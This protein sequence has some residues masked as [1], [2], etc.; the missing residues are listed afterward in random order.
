MKLP[1]IN[2]PLKSFSL[3][4]ATLLLF[5]APSL[6]L[7]GITLHIS[8]RLA[9]AQPTQE[10]Q[11]EADQL[12]QQGIEQLNNSQPEA[13]LQL[14]QQALAIYQEL[15]NRQGE[16]QVLKNIG[17]TY[18]GL[19]EYAK[20]IE[21]HEQ[22]LAIAQEL[23]DRDL[24]GKALNNLGLAYKELGDSAKAIEYYQ[25]ALV[26]AREVPSSELEQIVLGNLVVIYAAL[27]EPAKVIEYAKPVLLAAQA[28]ENTLLEGTALGY[29]GD[30]SVSLKNYQQGIDYAQQ[31]LVIA[32]ETE[33]TLLEAY[34]F[35]ILSRAYSS[36]ENYQKVIEYA[37]QGLLAAQKIENSWLEGRALGQ[38]GDTHKLRG[39]MRKAIE[40]AQQSLVIAQESGNR[41]LESW[42][43]ITLSDAY[44]FIGDHLQAIEYAQQ[45][46]TIAQEIESSWFQMLALDTLGRAYNSLGQTE[47]SIDFFQ[48]SLTIAQ[49]VSSPRQEGIV[50]LNLSNNYEQ[51]EDYQKAI[52]LLEQSLAIGRKSKNPRLEAQALSNLS[53]V[54]SSLNDYK[55]AIELAEQSW[56]IAQE[57][58]NPQALMMPLVSLYSIYESLGDYQKLIEVS[59]RGLTTAQ[60]IENPQ[61]EILFL[62]FLGMASFY[63]GDAQK[64]IELSQQSLVIAEQNESKLAEGIALL[65]LS[66][67]YGELK[68]YEKAIE[69]S[70]KSLTIAKELQNSHIERTVLNHL[71]GIYRRAGQKKQ[72]L[73][74]YQEALAIAQKSQ[75]DFTLTNALAGM[76]LVYR[77]LNMPV[78]AITY[79]KQ[80]IN[81][82][83][84]VRSN[85]SGLSTELQESFL[86]AIWDF[87]RFTRADFYRELA[88]LLL[89]QGRILEAQQVLE[90]LKVQELRD[91][92]GN[93]SAG[94]EKPKVSLTQTEEQIK[95]EHGTL[96]AFGQKV[97]EC[98]AEPSC[99]ELEQM[100]QQLDALIVQ[101]NQTVQV[102]EEKVQNR[103]E[104]DRAFL[105]TEDF[106]RKAQEIVKAQPHTVL[107]YPFVLDDKIWLLWS[108]AG[109]IV[110]TTEVT[111]VGQQ[112]LS[113]TVL[114]FREQLQDPYSEI[115]ALQTTGK[116]LYDWLIKPLEK[117]LQGN[118]IQNLVFS[119]DRATR[120][121]PLSALFDGE[122]YLI[123]NYA[124][125]TV[126]S[127]KL[128]DTE[129]RLPSNPQ[130]TSVLAMGLSDAVEGFNPL[131]NVPPELDVI[132]LVDD[133]DSRGVYSGSQFL[134]QE[135]NLKALRK[136]LRGRQILHLAT[137]GEFVPGRPKESYILLGTGEK[138]AIADISR[139]Y[140][141]L[142]D[143]HLVVL[144]ACETALGGAGEDGVEINGISYYF[145]SNGA[146]AVMASLWLVNDASTSQLMQQFYGNLAN[147]TAIVPMT[148]AQALRQAQLSMLKDNTSTTDN[149]DDRASITSVS[150]SGTPN[151]STAGFSHPYY[152]APFILIGNGS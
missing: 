57:I 141:Q 144:S 129:A 87:D 137:H 104:K 70:R 11:T 84:Q 111:G 126:L 32:Q 98:E 99:N 26:I 50:L 95:E 33:N 120:Y 114:K 100:E 41:S 17:N 106:L 119:L 83:E 127:A 86:Q 28:V 15:K 4:V 25:Q 112:Q 76:A 85:I 63:Q 46:L 134:N 113:E 19:K 79:Y 53:D 109:G 5:M 51:L 56:V 30:A 14:F 151:S 38:L 142:S 42:N 133:Q 13:A 3:V 55:Q 122:Q 93:R 10:R 47:K 24:E 73:I 92:T 145:L 8:Y 52:E 117:E 23:Q 39:E 35:D 20:T 80:V 130:N 150:T 105:D 101:F 74:V 69:T 152:W 124:V 123:E 2:R 34:A 110:Q 125:F 138:L 27:E 107:I 31:A 68:N 40:Y 149:T 54:Y 146:K 48:K 139:L 115:T 37:Q 90:L 94:G 67:G 16:R 128:T 1:L 103:R 116:Q 22:A 136:N 102:I 9:Q 29:L 88:D 6:E 21:Y 64:A 132:V 91:F 43:L 7:A 75:D 72:A 60:A 62:N 131:P 108:S 12:F 65:V 77:D 135:F 66:V 58:K 44:D 148:K 96:I 143:V 81:E 18:F 89:S 140:R 78:T 71:G 59:Q 61:L 118:D 36:L 49:E 147:K 97:A 82:I 121:I 45:S